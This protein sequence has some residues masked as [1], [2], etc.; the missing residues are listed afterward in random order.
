MFVDVQESKLNSN[1]PEV[2]GNVRPSLCHPTSVALAPDTPCVHVT[3]HVPL[4]RESPAST[5]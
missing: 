2:P 5:A 4:S 1:L 3:L